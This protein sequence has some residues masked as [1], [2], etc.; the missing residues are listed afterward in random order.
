MNSF[1]TILSVF[2][3]VI[4]ALGLISMRPILQVLLSGA[5]YQDVPGKFELTVRLARVMFGFVALIS[6]Y[7]YFTSVLAS[8]RRFTVAAFAPCALNLTM[9]AAAFLRPSSWNSE[10]TLSWAVVV[11][12]GLQVLV[13][14]PALRHEGVYLRWQVPVWSPELKKILRGILPG[15]L[16]VSLLQLTM[17]INIYFASALPQGT[18][19]YFY[20]ADRLLELPLALFV[21]SV[22]STL[23]PLLT[24]HWVEGHKERM[25]SLLNHALRLITVLALP[26]ALGLFLL[27]LPIVRLLFLGQEFSPADA[28]QTSQIIQIYAFLL[29]SASLTRVFAQGFYAIGRVWFPALVAASAL[30]VH[31]GAAFFLT[32]SLGLKGL[33]LSSVISSVLNCF[34]LALRTHAQISAVEWSKWLGSLLRSLPGLAVVTIICLFYW[35]VLPLFAL[36]SSVWASGFLLICLVLAA[37]GYFV[38]AWIFKVSEVRELFSATLTLRQ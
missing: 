22:G 30:L 7:A 17:I 32:P 14:I 8:F 11:G 16:G 4:T 3:F 21:I 12:G 35:Q 23:L 26:S 31:F 33:A 29:V 24:R 18:N 1:F 34:I 2:A 10:E 27:A 19:T 5:S 38:S 6:L 25:N 28:L 36:V 9:I 13:L 15:L 37:A 20:L